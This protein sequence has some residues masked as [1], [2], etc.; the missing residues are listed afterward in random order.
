M[1]KDT[2]ALAM[3]ASL[4]A[5]GTLT[6]VS[7]VMAQGTITPPHNCFCEVPDEDSCTGVKMIASATCDY[8]EQVCTRPAFRDPQTGCVESLMALCKDAPTP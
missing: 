2:R 8:P 5:L 4:A 6:A 1:L 7:A 3:G